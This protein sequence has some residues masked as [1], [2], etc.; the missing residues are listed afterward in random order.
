[1]PG[2]DD[3]RERVRR[4]LLRDIARL[5]AFREASMERWAALNRLGEA[6]RQLTRDLDAP[7]ER[8]DARWEVKYRLDLD[9]LVSAARSLTSLPF[10]DSPFADDDDTA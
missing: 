10:P 2:D 7:D 6:I 3:E 1:M 9:E 4:L 8:H 5:Q